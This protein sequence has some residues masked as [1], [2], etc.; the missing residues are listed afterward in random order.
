M[1]ESHA[2]RLEESLN[3]RNK[4][5]QKTRDE[6]RALQRFVSVIFLLLGV[7]IAVGLVIVLA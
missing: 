7:A 3:Q 1:T 4:R 5:I 6:L 2:G